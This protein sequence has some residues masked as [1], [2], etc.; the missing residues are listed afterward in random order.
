MSSKAMLG[1]VVLWAASW[2]FGELADVIIPGA[3]WPVFILLA[4]V[5]TGGWAMAMKHKAADE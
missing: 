4:G 5:L 1:L 2:G 3:Q